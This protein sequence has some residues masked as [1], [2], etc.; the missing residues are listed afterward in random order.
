MFIQCS[1][2]D[3]NLN[4]SNITTKNLLLFFDVTI[5]FTFSIADVYNIITISSFLTFVD[6]FVLFLSNVPKKKRHV[7][8]VGYCREW[9]YSVIFFWNSQ[10]LTMATSI[11][12]VI[13]RS[14]PYF[15]FFYRLAVFCLSTFTGSVLLKK[16]VSCM[17]VRMLQLFFFPRLSLS[18]F[19]LY[20]F[21]P[22][23]IFTLGSWVSSQE[24]IRKFQLCNVHTRTIRN[25]CE[26]ISC[27]EMQQYTLTAHIHTIHMLLLLE[28]EKNRES[29]RERHR[30]VEEKKKKK[31]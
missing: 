19:S 14:C 10:L 21:V 29:E 30:E 18:I 4:I 28:E 25:N 17:N 7:N 22:R 9:I 1:E 27:K 11:P 13:P 6:I 23:F 12:Y 31:L 24:Y 5:I 15:F 26:R 2:K 16:F 8:L 20:R 3:E